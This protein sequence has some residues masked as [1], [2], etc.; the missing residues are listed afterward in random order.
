[1]ENGQGR[2]FGYYYEVIKKE[3]VII[4]FHRRTPSLLRPVMA[5]KLAIVALAA[6]AV[7][8]AP[9]L[10]QEAPSPSPGSQFDIATPAEFIDALKAS[11]LEEECPVT[12]LTINPALY[13]T[14]Q[15]ISAEVRRRRP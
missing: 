10:A 8:A 3:K 12:A 11:L 14:V 9:A 6:A 2:Y 4:R 13:G 5:N 1:M 7:A 15:G